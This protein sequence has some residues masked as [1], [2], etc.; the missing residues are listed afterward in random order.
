MPFQKGQSGNP[1][2][3]PKVIGVVQDLARQHTSEAINTL[4]EIMN[5]EKAQPAQRIV[6]AQVMLDRG[7]G[8]P[9]QALEGIVNNRLEVIIKDATSRGDAID[10]TPAVANVTTL[11]NKCKH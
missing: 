9:V 10:V 4:A 5:D 3:R 7:W 11:P 2:G 6:A 8:K 1:G